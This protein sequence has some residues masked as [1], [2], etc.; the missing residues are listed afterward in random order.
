MRD[1]LPPVQPTRDRLIA[2]AS[3]LMLRQSYAT[4]SVDDICREAEIKK[5]TFYHHFPSKIELALATFDH[6]WSECRGDMVACI[7][8]V[9]R[10][11][12]ERLARFADE[13]VACHRDT[14]DKEGKVYGCPF[15]NAGSEMAAQDDQIR[16]KIEGIFEEAVT[17]LADLVAEMPSHA[18]CSR[19][20]CAETARAMFCFMTGVE[21]QAKVAN[22]PDVIARD[23]LPGLQ[24]LL[25]SPPHGA[26][27]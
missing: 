21:Y 4:V 22:N 8:D 11:P 5:G 7:N 1:S 17:L 9:G 13:V 20:Q 2:A 15:S 26:S 3:M 10:T 18:D 19:A 25:D 27:S 16:L 12:Q 24:R 14:F 23:L 6:I